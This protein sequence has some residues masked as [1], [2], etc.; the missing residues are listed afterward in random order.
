MIEQIIP[1]NRTRL[2]IIRA[3]YEN[4]GINLTH[5]IRKVKASPNLVLAY[6]NELCSYQVV[7]EEKS[8]GR[9]KAHVRNFQADFSEEIA[10]VIYSL[11]EID[12][13][14][15][16]LR[17]YKEL[18]SYFMQL[19]DI[20][21]NKP[22]FVLVYGSYARL[23]A[24]PESDLDLLIVGKLGEEELKRIREVF[25]TWEKELSLKVE[26]LEQFLKN[27]DKPLYQNILREHVVAY[28]A[29]DFIGVLRKLAGR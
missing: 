26:T 23:A 9:K 20:L 3:V 6:V 5:L 11:V 4:P 28:G 1:G 14:E 17:K 24:A 12:K 8:G 16:F 7:R 21:R 13:K 18:K 10:R 29:G 27:K 25:V 2:K 19:K 22:G 15:L